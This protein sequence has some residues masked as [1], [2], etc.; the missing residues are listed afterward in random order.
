[1]GMLQCGYLMSY[2]RKMVK[3]SKL[4]KLIMKDCPKCL[5]YPKITYTGQ[6]CMYRVECRSCGLKTN[7]Y[8]SS[9]EAVK[10]WNERRMQ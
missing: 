2:Q 1:M 8:S 10:A 5:I 9:E 7:W 3:M 4:L 6:S